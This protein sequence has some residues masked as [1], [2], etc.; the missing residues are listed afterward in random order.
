MSK[1]NVW[2]V[3]SG[4][5][6]KQC[7]DIFIE[8]G[9]TIKGCFDNWCTN[10][11]YKGIT[12]VDTI[13]NMDQYINNND[14]IFCTIGD[15]NKR[16][17]LVEKYPHYNWINCISKHSYISS[18][19]NIGKGNYIGVGT[20]ILADSKIGNFNICNDGSTMTHDNNIKDYNHLAPNCSLGGKVNI[21]NN[22]LIGTN[23]TVNPNITICDNV[24]V[25]SGSVVVK[26][27]NKEGIYK[28]VPAK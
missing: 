4:G 9:Y 23:A 16:K 19:V 18:S 22:C 7:I 3:Q 6:C 28:G 15:N 17:Q 2:L 5:H 25:G 26:N 21:G 27:I 12:I 11:F 8:N 20:K 13:D 14:P 24:V 10:E 1:L